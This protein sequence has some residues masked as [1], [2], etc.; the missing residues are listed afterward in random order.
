MIKEINEWFEN[1]EFEQ[2]S[3]YGSGCV[4][5]DRCGDKFIYI[6]SGDINKQIEWKVKHYNEI[7]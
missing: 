6:P 4:K 5:C 3:H 1:L 7:F 2:L